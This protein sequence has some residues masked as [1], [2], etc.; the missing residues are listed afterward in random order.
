M[1]TDK[2]S[3]QLDT[4][5]AP[6]GHQVALGQTCVV[7]DPETKQIL[8]KGEVGELYVGGYGTSSGYYLKPEA[9]AEKFSE[10]VNETMRQLWPHKWYKTGDGAVI[11]G[12]PAMVEIRGRI[13]STVKIRGFKVGMPV[14]ES[15]IGSIPGVG[16]AAVFPV[17][18]A[19][20]VV[21]SLC[22]YLRPEDRVDYAELVTRVKKEGPTK[23][24][25]WMMP[26]YYKPLPEDAFTGGEARKLDRKRLASS[27]DLKA[28]QEDQQKSS[29]PEHQN[30]EPVDGG[31]RGIVRMVWAKALNLN[32]RNLDLEENFFDLGGHSTLAAQI[33]TTLSET[34]ELPIT[35]L[36]IYS[37]STLGELL[38][39]LDPQPVA[40]LVPSLPDTKVD[41][42]SHANTQLAIVGM[43]GVFPDAADVEEF[44]Q[45]LRAGS[46]SATFLSKEFLRQKGVP[47]SVI[48]DKEFVPC[49]YM[50]NDADKF[51]HQFFG[52][53][54]HEA[55]LMDP[56]HRVFIETSWAAMENAGLNPRSGLKD[57]VV[58]VFAAAGIDGYLVHHL[59]GAPLKDTMDPQD[60]FLAEI[61]NEKDYIAT[62]VAYLMNFT[63]P[64]MNVNS[65]CSSALVACAQ[66]GAAIMAGQCDAVVAGASSITF[67][68]LGFRYQDGLVNSPDGYVRPFD[69]NAEGTVFGDSCGAVV[70]RRSDA[71]VELNWGVMR[72]FAVSN[73]GGRKAGYAAPSSAGQAQAIRGAL[74]MLGEDPW[75][76]SYIEAHAT[77]TR[78]GDGIEVR[79]LIDAFKQVGGMPKE[80][81]K[82][83]LG[84]VK[85]NIAHANC[86]AGVTGLA[87]VLLMMRSR[88]LVPVANFQ[89]LSPKIDIEGTPFHV[90]NELR[91][92]DADGKPLRAGVSSFGIGGTNAHAVIEEAPKTDE[93]EG[94]PKE[95]PVKTWSY[96]LLPFS[97]KTPSALR[98]TAEK[99][100]AGM[101]KMLPH[102]I[103][104]DAAANASFTLQTTRAEFAL[105]KAVVLRTDG[106]EGLEALAS[107]LLEKMPTEDELDDIE[108]AAKKPTLTLVFPGQ[109][110]QYFGMSRGLYDEV[111]LFK[112]VADQCCELLN[113]PD[114]LGFD[115]RPVIFST[116]GGD[117]KEKDREE[118][119]TR[120][121]VMQPAMFITEYALAQVF[122]AVGLSPT[123]TAGHSL[124]EYASAVI[125]GF[126][127][128]DAAC[129]I[130]AAR[131]KSTET[132]AEDGAMLSVANWTQEE[133]DAVGREE[134]PGLWLAAVNSPEHAVISGET[135]AIDALEKELKDA[136]K[137]CTKLHVQK[138]FH[139]GLIAKAADTL[140]GLGLPTESKSTIP[141][142]SNLTGEWL[143]AGQLKEG[144]YWRDHMRGTVFWRQCAETMITK[145]Q[146]AVVLECGP[147]SALSVL[148]KKCV[149]DGVATPVFIQGMRHPKAAGVHDAEA[150]LGALSQLWER[151]F[152]IDWAALHGKVMG[153]A[154]LPSLMRLPSYGFDRTSLWTKPK[155]SIHVDGDDEAAE[156]ESTA[157]STRDSKPVVAA[158][159]GLVRFG[160][161]ENEPSMRAYCLPFA[162]GSSLL[163][164]PW[165]ATE[166]VDDAVEVVALE[167][168]GRG[169]R[170]EETMPSNDSEDEALLDGF[171]D[172]IMSDLRGAQYTLVGFSMGGNLSMELTLRL[173]AKGAPMPLSLY[174]AGRRPPTTDPASVSTTIRMSDKELAD[175]AFAPPEVAQAKEF[176]EHVV[177]L[178]RADLELDARLERRLSSRSQ[179]GQM[180][181]RSVGLELCCGIADTIAP[182]T[183]V[184]AWQRFSLSPVGVH[185]FPGGHEFLQEQRPLLFTMWRRDAIN[186]LVQRRSAELA[187]LSA[188]GF[189]SPGSAVPSATTMG[190]A[191]ST[192]AAG[193]EGQEPLPLYAVRWIG[194]ERDPNAVD[195]RN[196]PFT[197]PLD[198][199]IPEDKLN[200]VVSALRGGQ[201]IMV[202]N[203]PG[204]GVLADGAVAAE[205]ERCWRFVS[206]VQ[207]ILGAGAA[208]R[209]IIAS[210]AAATGAMV[211][212]ASKA[213]AM[214]A[215]ELRI[216][217]VFVPPT[218]FSDD[219]DEVVIISSD[220]ADMYMQE[221]DLWIQDRALAGDVYTQRIEPVAEQSQKLP[222]V[223]KTR[224][225]GRLATYV[226]TGATGGL[227]SALVHWLINDQDLSP[228]QLVLL[229]RAGSRPLSGELAQCRVVEVSDVASEPALLSSGLG[230]VKDIVGVF[231][232]AG[233]LDD[234]IVQGMTADRLRSVVEPKCGMLTALLRAAALFRWPLQWILGFSSTSSL[235]GYGG[236]SNY[237]AANAMLDH[238]AAFSTATDLPT[239]DRLPCKFIAVNW[240]PWGEAGMA[241]EG[242]KAYEQ[243]VKEGD[244]PLKTAVAL[245]CLAS[246][247]RTA[248][249]AQ[250][251]AVQFAACDVDWKKST[252]ADLP[253]LGLVHEKE[254]IP[255]DASDA[256]DV[257][258]EAQALHAAI[259]ALFTKHAGDGVWRKNTNK[260]LHQLGFDSFDTVQLRNAFNKQFGVTVPLSVFMDPRKAAADILQELLGHVAPASLK[261]G[262]AG[263]EVVPMAEAKAK[264]IQDFLVQ[265]TSG[266][267]WK[268]IQGKTLSQLALD[269][270]EV[271]QLRNTFNKKFGVT[272]PLKLLSDPSLTVATI[273]TSLQDLV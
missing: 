192:A 165:M 268:R 197:V 238:L 85:G 242:T 261:G 20:G 65:A 83:A 22:C 246:A 181:P 69:V 91:H 174:I 29:S 212:G 255:G 173:A 206:L 244:T 68:N 202:I 28:L 272:A 115:L 234:G 62:R 126:L 37:H 1:A 213:V 54:R 164:A 210:S 103:S 130:V 178:L 196:A 30:E 11:A 153:I 137:K 26:T 191:L 129:A 104:I 40:P 107:S 123:A 106:A 184:Q 249:Q 23:M 204:K 250:R 34:H 139:S 260:P 187:V 188:Q 84:S 15:G 233:V 98:K 142:T 56:Q 183:E 53:N 177:P 74:Q 99:V 55:S 156:T 43:A 35:V 57:L 140:K 105:R 86:A 44:W 47:D 228:Q 264:T 134:K 232:L 208:G 138:A 240:G 111:P 171:C 77:G 24:P 100:S 217:R 124:G 67:P 7:L 223:P 120:A 158:S 14:V 93:V 48:D 198:C 231:H 75:S 163:F 157:A 9:T 207:H 221:S 152:A 108:D 79:G 253:I 41:H 81:T 59:D 155:R 262:K 269:S 136:G 90:N 160:K 71:S 143:S 226:L 12:E 13:D 229:R 230:S 259:E 149:P 122:L 218:C 21:D 162:S 254:Q 4:P 151:G 219:L 147:G 33:A 16:L 109:G 60:I 72:G 61:G 144:T 225:D 2:Q 96:Q 50:I 175:Y 45:N 6:A 132:L 80:G 82:V 150:L 245:R 64:A 222:C 267:S 190:G 205:T 201:V 32:M 76:L 263:K 19:P 78:V 159:V 121:S 95:L 8:P 52:I 145:H 215:S 70:I 227:G 239:G 180:L 209:I 161:R 133:L 247:L 110:S 46:C 73:D 39:F 220:V 235:F 146:P 169:A 214:E 200:G 194:A 170:I 167:L 88:E 42:P 38:E 203:A 49:A 66:G 195:S 266:G 112:D 116:S 63:G 243:A 51:D 135:D 87:K 216:Q 185:Y 141:M 258:D 97:A 241:K 113:K 31:V 237:C 131:A 17:F 25:Q 256:D 125:G 252:W 128:L 186:R 89:T 251:D 224:R 119:F 265:H 199:D 5:F 92:W 168:P 3:L 189:S 193:R 127:S 179:A 271:V 18:S 257:E 211:V 101:M 58:G 117:E 270:L 148:S 176:Q 94:Q 182:Y 236:Q 172:A 102:L 154:A 248:T 114:M 10:G 166:F 273:A 27:I 36:D 118:Q